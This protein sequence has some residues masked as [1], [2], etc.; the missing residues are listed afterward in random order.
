MENRKIIPYIIVFA[1]LLTACVKDELHNTPHPDCGVAQISTHWSKISEDAMQPDS[2][3]L[4]IGELTY[5]VSG[6]DN[7]FKELL[8][9]GTYTLLVHNLPH[10]VTV[11]S[12]TATINT[13]PDGTLEPR[14]EYLFSAMQQFNVK[15]DDTL[16]VDVEMVQSI[17]SLTLVLKLKPGD[18]TRIAS[19]HATLT[20]VAHSIDL[21]TGTCD[22]TATGKSVKP[23]F[24]LNT[25]SPTRTIETPAL[26]A[27]LR[28]AGIISDAPKLLT[29]AVR[30]T[31][32]ITQ[33]VETDLTEA[34]KDFGKERNPLMLD[35]TLQLP[36]EGDMS[37]TATVTN[38][39]PGNGDGETGNAE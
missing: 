4:R 19:T 3:M 2:Y 39:T 38:W 26:I 24:Q 28:L 29:L 14:P 25:P 5:P 7:T 27:T 6:T 18:D 8:S 1:L 11:S 20:G 22:A 30:L 34:L 37:V 15:Q 10:G 12:A 16:K 35:A 9:E 23:S 36:D 31:N 17:R 13:L 33:T 32:G 21:Y